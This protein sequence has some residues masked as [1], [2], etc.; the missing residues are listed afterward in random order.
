MPAIRYLAEL[1]KINAEKALGP[2]IH[3]MSERE[4]RVA[5]LYIIHGIEIYEA[6]DSAREFRGLEKG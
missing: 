6:I 2:I 3:D 1:D 5:L 4:L